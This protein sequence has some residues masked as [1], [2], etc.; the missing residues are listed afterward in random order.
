[1]NA[2]AHLATLGSTR[3]AIAAPGTERRT[4]RSTIRAVATTPSYSIQAGFRGIRF[5]PWTFIPKGDVPTLGALLLT[6]LDAVGRLARLGTLRG[7]LSLC[8]WK[9]AKST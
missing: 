1:M 7:G 9:Q 3:S 8:A 6:A 2:L 4:P 5:A